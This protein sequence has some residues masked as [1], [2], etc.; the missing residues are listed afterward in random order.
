MSKHNLTEF[1]ELIKLNIQLK[2]L[3]LAIQIIYLYFII[4]DWYIKDTIKIIPP[5]LNYE[6]IDDDN[7]FRDIYYT[8]NGTNIS[9]VEF[10]YPEKINNNNNDNSCIDAI[11]GLISERIGVYAVYINTDTDIYIIFIF[12][13]YKKV[14]LIDVSN[15]NILEFGTINDCIHHV[16]SHN[17]RYKY[18]LLKVINRIWA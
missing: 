1:F 12:H 2:P 7:N 5:P 17:I 11:E 9:L 3:Q 13:F 18:Q 14:I 8:L 16:D 15:L 4:K 6:L 10:Q